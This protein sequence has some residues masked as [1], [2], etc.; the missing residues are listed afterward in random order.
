M[1]MFPGGVMLWSDAQVFSLLQRVVY[2]SMQP[3]NHMVSMGK[4]G[5]LGHGLAG[6]GPSGEPLFP[7]RHHFHTL[8]GKKL[9]E[10]DC[11][12]CLLF[13][14]SSLVDFVL[15]SKSLVVFHSCECLQIINISE[16][17]ISWLVLSVKYYWLVM[18][19]VAKLAD[20]AKVQDP[21]D[22]ESKGD[23]HTT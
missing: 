12:V 8:E 9:L 13:F 1:C 6:Y 22:S 18:A 3:G 16:N 10:K 20:I 14:L 7:S 15:M 11:Y 21:I 5:L 4:T 2:H 19:P 23:M 17:V